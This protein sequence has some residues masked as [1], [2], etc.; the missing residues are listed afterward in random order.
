VISSTIKELVNILPE[1]KFVMVHAEKS[2]TTN[3]SI[4]DFFEPDV[5]FAT[6]I[7]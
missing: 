3:L 4:E 5:I 2:F 7:T 6:N 1:A